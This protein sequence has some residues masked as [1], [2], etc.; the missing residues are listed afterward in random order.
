M[1]RCAVE[2]LSLV[3][4]VPLTD[5]LQCEFGAPGLPVQFG[6]G[7]DGAITAA[8]AGGIKTERQS[9]PSATAR[10]S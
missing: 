8:A 1:F 10:A 5:V 6:T 7:S 4:F 3:L 9:P 2:D